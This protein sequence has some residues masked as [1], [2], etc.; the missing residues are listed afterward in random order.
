MLFSGSFKKPESLAVLPLKNAVLF[1]GSIAPMAVGRPFSLKAVEAAQQGDSLMAVFTQYDPEVENPTGADLYHV[2]TLAK[3]LKVV[4][5]RRGG[6]TV[7]L[8]GLTRLKIKRFTQM[9]PYVIVEVD[10]PED[11]LHDDIELMALASKLKELAGQVI[12][13]S[14]GIPSEARQFVEEMDDVGSLADLVAANMNLPQDQKMAILT[15]LDVKERAKRVI[16]HLANELELLRLKKQIDSE[17]KGEM[18]RSQREYYLRKQMEAIRKE[19][20][21]GGDPADDADDLR[22]RIREAN[23]PEEVGKTADKEV[24]KLQRI[25]PSSPEY[26]VSTNYLDWILDLPWSKSSKEDLDIKDAER[27]LDEDH[28]GLEKVK[29]RILEFL[30]VRKLKKDMKGPILCLIGPPGVGKT[31]L[32]RSVARAMGREFVR[33]SLGGIHDEAE[34]RGHRRTYIGSMPGRIIQGLKKAGV[35]NPVYM[36]DELDKIGSDFRGDPSS[37]LLEVL[38]PEQN[39]SFQDN[40]LNLPFDLSQ[41][42]FIGTANV[43]DT[44]PRPL[45]D[46]MEV[47]EVP[48]YTQ[49]EKLVIAK[50]Y[51]IKEELDNHGLTEEQLSITDDGLEKIVDAYT[52]EAGVRSLKRNIAAICRGAARIIASGDAES[53][54][55]DAKTIR[56]MLGPE[57]F[58]PEVAERTSVP[59]VATGMAWTPTGGDILFIEATMMKGKGGLMLT[60]QLGEVM[61]ESAR[62]ALSYI[63]SKA[64]KFHID[65]EIFDNY[66]IH[67]HI[68]AGAI[69]KD[70]PSAGIT[71]LSALASLLTGRKVS[72]EMA[73]T[74]E[75]TLR[76]QILPVGGIKEKILAAKRAGIKEVLLPEKNKKDLEEIPAKII[77]GL[78][79]QFISKID[80]ALELA[81]DKESE[82]STEEG[83]KGK[84]K[85]PD[86]D[87]PPHPPINA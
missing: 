74:G 37:A 40:Y 35:N 17:V 30:A 31:S 52:R 4:D 42:M 65:P 79:L 32:G 87:T 46:R 23:L 58:F 28:Y 39:D 73:M 6:K 25:P 7:L 62:A 84:S 53:I 82:N 16:E 22:R 83:G 68:P 34:I 50:N 55:A 3:I 60:G 66:D 75:V 26:T 86:A 36:L 41:V 10:Y 27:I 12:T 47:I 11:V 51:L 54:S 13:N 59:G 49:E 81:L 77:E 67:I 19:L 78:H 8:Q 71:L 43:A 5:E 20:G 2:G 85:K 18:D 33:M 72:S 1:P 56:E 64:E 57:R 48:G 80:D 38:D 21:E 76:G 9:S 29:K 69:P 70:G 15:I 61:K 44:I 45:W 24:D 14:P 63:R